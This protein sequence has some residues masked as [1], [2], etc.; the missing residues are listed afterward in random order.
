M[1]HIQQSNVRVFQG[2]LRRQG[3]VHLLLDRFVQLGGFGLQASHDTVFV[4]ID[5]RNEPL[6]SSF[7]QSFHHI[8]ARADGF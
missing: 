4:V 7:Q 3:Q 6:G 5:L 2:R 8:F 1:H